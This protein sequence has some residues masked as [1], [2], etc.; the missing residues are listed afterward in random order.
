VWLKLRRLHAQPFSE[1]GVDALIQKIDSKTDHLLSTW[2]SWQPE[3][4]YHDFFPRLIALTSALSVACFF[5]HDLTEDDALALAHALMDG[6]DYVFQGILNAFQTPTWVPVPHVRRYNKAITHIERI[7]RGI[8]E[9][10]AARTDVPAD[11]MAGLIAH[12]GPGGEPLSAQ[13][14]RDQVVTA[15]TAAPE[16]MATAL[17]WSLHQSHVT[18]EWRDR[19]RDPAQSAQTFEIF[20]RE[21]LRIYPGAPVMTRRALVDDVI[22]GHEVPAGSFVILSPYA[23]HRNPR[24]WSDPERFFPERPEYARIRAGE[25][26]YRYIPFGAGPRRCVGDHFAQSLLGIVLPKLLR[27]FKFEFQPG[28]VARPAPRI[29]LRPAHGLMLRLKPSSQV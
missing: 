11:L 20:M 14:L 3:A 29:N 28:F 19:L 13:E 21:I 26:R 15:L 18:P 4:E 10:R 16:N 9:A 5:S 24:F 25:D 2:T 27:R 17:T 22:D 12:R 8:L 7:T 1:R 23:V 6:Q